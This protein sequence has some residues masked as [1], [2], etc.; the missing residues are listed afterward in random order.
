VNVRDWDSVCASADWLKALANNR[1]FLAEHLN[2]ELLNWKQSPAANP[3]TA[4]TIILGGGR[5]FLVRANIWMPPSRDPSMREDQRQLFLYE[6]PHDHNFSFLT[7]GYFG[8]GYET[9]IYEYDSEKIQGEVGE[10]VALR[11]LER[12]TLPAGK[13]MFYRA[14]KDI[15]TQGHPE[16]FSISLNLL[17]SPPEVN[18]KDQYLFDLEAS[19]IA[20]QAKNPTSSRLMM[21]RVARYIGNAQTAELLDILAQK[22]SSARIRLTATES[23]AGLEP[24][25][26]RAFWERA[27]RDVSPLV[28]SC[29][30]QHLETDLP[31]SEWQSS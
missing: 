11:F 8:S 27:V 5:D 1:T 22:H 28:S 23:L 25:N 31:H 30:R 3:Y 14:S 24:A 26:G 19:R 13:M 7:V 12:T 21:C 9:T 10:K 29:A 2:Q 17:L 18:Q 15:H 16:E 20:Q 6:V 4:Q